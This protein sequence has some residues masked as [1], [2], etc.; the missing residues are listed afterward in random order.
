MINSKELKIKDNTTN[1][2]QKKNETFPAVSLSVK[3]PISN[4]ILVSMFVLG[5]IV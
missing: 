2:N 4:K 3:N 1:E 5:L